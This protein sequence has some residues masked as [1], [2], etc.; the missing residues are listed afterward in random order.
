MGWFEAVSGSA[1]GKPVGHYMAGFGWG[2]RTLC[3]LDGAGSSLVVPWHQPICQVCEA[4]RRAGHT[5]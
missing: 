4:K 1:S 2:N 5:H 3:G